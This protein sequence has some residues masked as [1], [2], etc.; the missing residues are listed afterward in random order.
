MAVSGDGL[1][2][3]WRDFAVSASLSEEEALCRLDMGR[4]TKMYGVESVCADHPVVHIWRRGQALLVADG[5]LARM[6]LC[7]DGADGESLLLAGLCVPMSSCGVVLV[8]GALVDA[9]AVGGILFVGEAGVGKSTQAALWERM[10]GGRVLNGDRVLVRMD[11][12]AVHP[13]GYGSPW[14]GSSPYRVNAHASVTLIA[15]LT[16]GEFAEV[17]SLSPDEAMEVLLRHTLLPSWA[18]MGEAAVHATETVVRLSAALPAISLRVPEGIPAE[19]VGILEA[20]LCGR[21]VGHG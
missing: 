1:S 13:T 11:A 4:F 15:E 16:R 14:S 9:P 6:T 18:G 21:G 19:G 20:Y 5:T 2:A 3:G 12:E 8:H 17:R 7:G 10:R